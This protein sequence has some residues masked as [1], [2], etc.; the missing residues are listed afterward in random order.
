MQTLKK[1]I[2]AYIFTD[3]FFSFLTILLFNLFFADLSG[4]ILKF[5]SLPI[6]WL[7]FYLLTGSYSNSLFE[8]SRLSELTATFLHTIFGCLVL[9]FVPLL[10]D[11]NS[12]ERFFVYNTLQFILVFSGR[13]ILLFRT[14]KKI[15]KGQ[16]Y[17]NTLIV[18]NN[19]KSIKIFEAL[20]KNFRYL[21]FKAIGFLTVHQNEIKNGLSKWIPNLGN[22]DNINT[23]IDENNIQIVILSIDKK[24]KQII[25]HLVSSLIKKEIDIKLVPDTLDILSGSIKTS[26]VLGAMLINLQTSALSPKEEYF[27]RLLDIIISFLGIIFFSPLLL[28]V[29]IKTLFSSKGAAIYSQERIG[30]KGK[31]FTIYKFRSM[32]E[33][34]EIDGPS[35]SSDNDPRITTWGKIMRKW[36]I[37]EL[38]QLWNI[39]KGDMSLVGPR[40]ERKMYID[41][42]TSK[43]PYY[44]Y[45][46]KAK[47]GITSWGMVQFGYASNIEEMLERMQYD[48][49]YIENASLLL[50]FKIMMHTFRIILSGKGK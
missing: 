32:Y 48:L 34:A 45:L 3:Y 19:P 22:V 46:L 47:P 40:P 11:I 16:I 25:E 49:I 23:I 44:Q 41:L 27:K 24:D 17:F 29:F 26:N 21:G 7:L 10:S 13:I 31:P 36:R 5:I 1:N 6:F 2:S 12:I 39:L 9:Y 43:S 35:L 30:Y 38:P 15:A 4:S 28:F 14:K 50:D 42:L 37:D 18:G 8:K 33:N 20:S